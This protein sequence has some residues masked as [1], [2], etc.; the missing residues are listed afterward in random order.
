MKSI[1]ATALLASLA[2]AA[3]MPSTYS[4]SD[5]TNS[6]PV[7]ERPL[8]DS[9]TTAEHNLRTFTD[10][11]GYTLLIDY[12]NTE[13]GALLVGQAG[14]DGIYD[15]GVSPTEAAS[16]TDTWVDAHNGM[17]AVIDYAHP[18]HYTVYD[19]QGSAVE[20]VSYEYA[21]SQP[22]EEASH[23][24]MTFVNQ[25]GYSLL[26]D[27]AVTDAAVLQVGQQGID[28]IYTLPSG[29]SYEYATAPGTDT[30][31]DSADGYV[32][33]VDNMHPNHYTVYD[34]ASSPIQT[35]SY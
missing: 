26:V 15:N 33:V 2:A 5:A 16:G 12:A 23:Y 34:S 19:S 14:I 17:Q 29:S 3:P 35:I 32:A 20:T 27:Q 21:A 28:G 7:S 4:L 31:V 11:N 6:E 25:D 22:T 30:W 18:N 1:F 10:A 13:L 24:M 8:P 9:T